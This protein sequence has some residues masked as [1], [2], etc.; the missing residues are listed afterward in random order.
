MRARGGATVLSARGTELES[1]LAFGAVRQLFVPVVAL[2]TAQ[3]ERLLVGPAALAAAVLGLRDMPHGA[4]ADPLYALSWLVTNLAETAPL[5]IA[6]DDIHWLD[7][8]SGRFVA[9]LAQRLESQPVLL[10]GTARP[11]E[12]GAMASP[13]DVFRDVAMVV[14]PAPL[15]AAAVAEIVGDAAASAEAHR[16]TGG[17]PFLLAELVRAIGRAP[18]GSRVDE[19]SSPAVAHSVSRRVRRIGSDAVAL[20]DAVSLFPAGAE[21]AEAGEVA[22]L[23]RGPAAAAAD[24]LIDAQVM[25]VEG[26]R[27]EYLHPLMRAAVYDALG[28]FARRQ[29]HAA[30]AEALKRRGA[31]AE[32]IAAQLL[33]GEP[34][35]SA[36]NVAILCAAAEQAIAAVAPRAAVRYL[37]RAVEEGAAEGAER[38]ALLLDLGRW[39]RVTGDPGAR[40]TLARA[41]AESVGTGDHVR[42]AIELAAT[43]YAHAENA[44]V[45]QTV[46]ATRGVEM[47]ADEQLTLDMLHAEA[48]GVRAGQRTRC[49]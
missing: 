49:G 8:E 13:L 19:L 45:V 3:R 40:D 18:P 24:A 37:A 34:A 9:Y 4:L 15:S 1:Q 32:E 25:R 22:G 21:L 35:Q 28:P 31:P 7:A 42:A 47:S 26:S 2:P 14:S 5:L 38:R 17:N 44:L 36:E 16:L 20:S 6:I 12:P 29:G 23:D 41:C 10:A 39:Q 27:L 30:A 33:A 46:A 11:R 48:C 43:A